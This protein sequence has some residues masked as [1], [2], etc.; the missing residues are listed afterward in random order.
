MK[1]KANN[2]PYR[3]WIKACL[4]FLCALVLFLSLISY[5]PTDSAWNTASSLPTQNWLGCIG[6]WIADALLQLFGYIAYIIPLACL[7]LGIFCLKETSHVRVRMYLLIPT[8]LAACWLLAGSG[9]KLDNNGISEWTK[10]GLGGFVGRYLYAWITTP[11]GLLLVL[12]WGL[13]LLAFIFSFKLPAVKGLTLT[14]AMLLWLANRL[15]SKLG[16]KIKQ[17]LQN[18]HVQSQ[19]K[20]IT[21]SVPKVK[22][23]KSKK[24]KAAT[25]PQNDAPTDTEH[26]TYELP[27]STLLAPIKTGTGAAFSKDMMAQISQKLESVLAQFGVQGKVVNASPGPVVTLYAFEPA[28]GVK[29]SRVISLA[30]DV[31][32]EMCV[33]SVRMAVVPGSNVIGIEMPNPKRETVFIRE[34]VE[35]PSFQEHVGALPIIL[36]KDIG[37]KAVFA[38]LAKMP[39]LLVAGTTG[40]GKSVG[41]NTMILS[42]LYRFTPEQCRLILVD[43][44]MVEL[45]VY[46][47]IPH[48]LT[49]VV[50]EPSK[51][52]MA[53]KWAVHEMEDRYRSL[54]QL[55]VRNISGFNEKLKQAREDGIELK[56][57]V[58]TG[59]DAATGQPIMEEQPFDL[60]PLPYIIFIIDEMADLMGQCGKEADPLIQRLAQMA[61]AVGIHLVLATQRPSVDVIT[62]TIRSNFPT[63]ISF[64]VRNKIDSRTILDEQGAEQLLGKGDMLYM[65]AGL[66][67]TRV[68]GPFVS[69]EDVA[70]VVNHW[71]H[72]GKPEYVDAVVAES[73]AMA[74]GSGGSFGNAGSGDGNSLYDQAVAIVL[75]DKKP[76]TSY[77]QRRL[78]IGYNKAADLIDRMEA[79]GIISA[80]NVA[81]K[82]EILAPNAGGEG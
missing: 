10:A 31:A 41:I 66:R 39:H 27:S 45:S 14:G 11:T 69:D 75:R 76:T 21:R 20:K 5:T 70:A 81:G 63:R 13:V 74:S 8:C 51:A 79:E 49:P 65:P 78:S 42:L 46:N 18:L 40:S 52:L 47:G 64:Q 1:R 32:R 80:P 56:R 35:L 82:R 15:P 19:I 71:V 33:V 26:N 34:M 30:E 4:L 50:T 72:Q 38:D 2:N 28:S 17:R 36:G 48:L 25:I 60:T 44:K 67:P 77:I 43:P 62:G 9:V 57:R 59:F 55:G 23:K 29:I 73:E 24:S 22:I 53:L 58:Q 68:H 12:T 6:A 61:R 16:T 54:S 7:I 37:G 3:H